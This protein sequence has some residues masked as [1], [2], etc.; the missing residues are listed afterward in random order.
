MGTFNPGPTHIGTGFYRSQMLGPEAGLIALSAYA[1]DTD[2][3]AHNGGEC[4]GISKNRAAAR[5]LGPIDVKHEAIL[6][7]NIWT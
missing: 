4:H 6:A 3:F 7:L 5:L 1:A 2:I